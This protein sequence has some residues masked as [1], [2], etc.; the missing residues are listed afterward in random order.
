M[1]FLWALQTGNKKGSGSGD[2]K[3]GSYFNR[4]CTAVCSPRIENYPN[5]AMDALPF[6]SFLPLH[7]SSCPPSIPF[8]HEKQ[9]EWDLGWY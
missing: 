7:S 6:S 8:P 5:Y 3:I 9:K 1:V 4:L 2:F